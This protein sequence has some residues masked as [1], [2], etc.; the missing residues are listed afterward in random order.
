[1]AASRARVEDGKK[2]T[3]SSAG[4][5]ANSASANGLK[6]LRCGSRSADCPNRGVQQI[7]R[8]WRAIGAMAA[9]GRGSRRF[10]FPCHHPRFFSGYAGRRPPQCQCR[11]EDSAKKDIHRIPSRSSGNSAP[12]ETRSLRLRVLQGD[13]PIQ[14]RPPAPPR[15]KV[16]LKLPVAQ[17]TSLEDQL[18]HYLSAA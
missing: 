6:P 3:S 8:C 5:R 1:V 11:G 2:T 15:L 10:Q 17:R 14:W 9:D 16:K 18:Q 7:A 13:P 4:W 12:Q